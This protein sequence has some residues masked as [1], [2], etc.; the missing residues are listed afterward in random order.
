VVLYHVNTWAE[1][2]PYLWNTYPLGPVAPWIRVPNQWVVINVRV[3][4]V[5][6]SCAPVGLLFISEI[7]SLS[8]QVM[9]QPFYSLY[10]LRTG[11]TGCTSRPTRPARPSRSRRSRRS[12]R[13][14]D[15][16]FLLARNGKEARKVAYLVRP[17]DCERSARLDQ[18]G[19]CSQTSPCVPVAP[20][21]PV[22][23]VTP[24]GPVAPVAPIGPVD[25]SARTVHQQ[26]AFRVILIENISC[27]P[28]G[29]DI[30]SNA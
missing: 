11:C 12:I 3:F 7:G 8:K 5:N 26:H 21:A 18:S 10:S 6:I 13:S 25:P 20:V 4:T 14:L 15:P 24:V 2:Q 9:N 23:P 22:A 30:V 17:W 28:V 29:L 16:Y 1:Q 19:E 27:A